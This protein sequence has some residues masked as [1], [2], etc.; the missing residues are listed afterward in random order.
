MH[1]PV[2]SRGVLDVSIPRSRAVRRLHRDYETRST[3]VLKTVGTR[4]YA[5]DPTTDV[6]CC[7]F[8]VDDQ[9]VVLWV[10]GD[11]I[12][13]ASIEAAKNRNWFA[14]AHGNHFESAIER[15]IMAPRFGWPEIPLERHGAGAWLAG[16]AE[17][18]GRCAGAR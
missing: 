2:A 1:N 6:L 13:W 16:E 9:P 4:K 3:A 7:A 15:H 18:S 8:A 10:P 11:P 12:P 14:V 17:C 5:A